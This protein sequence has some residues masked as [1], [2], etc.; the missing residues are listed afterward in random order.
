MLVVGSRPAGCFVDSDGR[1]DSP[2]RRTV[3]RRWKAV[4]SM[5]RVFISI[6]FIDMADNHRL[7]YNSAAQLKADLEPELR[8]HTR[9]RPGTK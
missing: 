7:S 9:L 3:V 2:S 5:R 4:I 8:V 6:S 1:S